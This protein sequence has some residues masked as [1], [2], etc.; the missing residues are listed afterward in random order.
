VSEPFGLRISKLDPPDLLKF[1]GKLLGALDSSPPEIF[2]HSLHNL[3]AA[4]PDTPLCSSVI[5]GMGIN[6]SFNPLSSRLPNLHSSVPI[7][8]RDA[9]TMDGMRFDFETDHAARTCRGPIIPAGSEGLDYYGECQP[10]GQT[11][12]DFFDCLALPRNG[13]LV[14]LGEVSGVGIGARIITSAVQALF[15]NRCFQALADLGTFVQELNRSICDIAPYDLYA[16]LF[17]AY[18]DPF[19]RQLQYVSAGHELALLFEQSS[20][21]LRRLECTGTVLGLTTRSGYRHRTIS[22]E[23]GEILVACTDGITDAVGVDGRHLCED[24]VVDV[25]RQ[26]SNAKAAEMGKRIMEA[27]ERI[28][29]SRPP[30]DDETVVIVRVLSAASKEPFYRHEEELAM[31]AA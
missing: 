26:N 18:M 14:F 28:R 19:R 27:A 23:A 9:R 11:F 31:A 15:R 17:C 6:Y 30:T 20:K 10:A 22:I 12:R 8:N 25:V 13:L 21:R 5:S 4:Q 3:A 24:G 29:A 2:N 16:T 1:R 7:S